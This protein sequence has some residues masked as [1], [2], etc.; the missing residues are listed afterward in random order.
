MSEPPVVVLLGTMDTKEDEYAFLH[1]K[2]LGSG[3]EVLL[4]NT[5]PLGD[6]AYPVDFD[7]WAVAA[8]GGSD[9][10]AVIREGDRGLAVSAMAEGAAALLRRLFEEGRVHGVLAMGGSGGSSISSRAMRELPVGLPKMLV[11]TMGAGDTRPFVGISD[12]AMVYSVVDIAGINRVSE[13]ILS[14]AAAGIAAMAASYLGREQGGAERPMLGATMYGSTTRCVDRARGWLEDAGYEV[15]VFH[16]TGT[17]GRSMEALMRSG[18]ITGALDITTTEITDEVAGGTMPA[19]PDRLEVAGS[20]GLP[21]VVSL[22]GIDIITF[23]PPEAVPAGWSGRT[24]YRHNPTVTLVRTTPEEADAVGRRLAGKLNR[25]SGPVT[26]FIPMR[27]TS[28]YGVAGGVFHDPEADR[29]LVDALTGD[30]G[31]GVEVVAMDTDINDPAF[32]VAM[33]QSL[34]QSYRRVFG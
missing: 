10:D 8:A 34:H 9:L 17:G 5:G 11:S 19:G 14:N 32:A 23:S 13:R 6:P 12:I 22:G 33:A 30:L 16:A 28:D 24:M 1:R 26:L 25:A 7:R 20:L 31:T 18:F 2:V 4:I 29:A 21:Q 27:G 15:L 3:A